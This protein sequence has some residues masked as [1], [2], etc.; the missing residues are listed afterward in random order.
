M[1]SEEASTK[2]EQFSEVSSWKHHPVSSMDPTS[3]ALPQKK[4]PSC[5][6]HLKQ[7]LV[8]EL[9]WQCEELHLAF[10]KLHLSTA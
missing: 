6:R 10:F 3:E 8:R 2:K 7:K 1:Y 4:R 9:W 5:S